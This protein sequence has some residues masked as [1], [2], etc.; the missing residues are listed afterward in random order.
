MIRKLLSTG[1]VIA[2]LATTL[3]VTA[4][5]APTPEQLAQRATE[6]RQAVFK[7]LGYNM[8]TISG[9]ARGTVEFDAE[10]AERNAQRI[11]AL[12]PMIPELFAAN[13]T[14]SFDVE[15]EAL[16]VIWEDLEGFTS[17]ANNL[18]EAANTFAATASGGDR[19]AVLGGLRA[20]GSTCG[21][22]HDAF[23]QE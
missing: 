9:M 18:L 17:K 3:S 14:R 19:A 1:L 2:S 12:A 7:L 11:A 22:C 5:Q 15:T 23:R 6:T 13:D 16:P 20:F 4:Q 21:S 10:I 8:G